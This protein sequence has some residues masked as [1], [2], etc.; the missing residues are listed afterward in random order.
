M[1]RRGWIT[2]AAAGACLLLGAAWWLSFHRS[3]T[4]TAAEAGRTR[5]LAQQRNDVASSVYGT[6]PVKDV[7]SA[8]AAARGGPEVQVLF[9]SLA[10]RKVEALPAVREGLHTG[11]MFEKFMLTKFLQY[12]PWPEVLADLV[13]LAGDRTQYWLPRQGALYALATLGDKAAGPAVAEIL[14]EPDC[15]QGVQLVA[16]AALARMDYR[17][18]ADTIRPF[19][20]REDIHMRLFAAHALAGWG[21][22][23]DPALLSAALRSDDYIARQEA[24]EVLAVTADSPELLQRASRD[25]PHE[26]VRD[27]AKRALLARQLRSETAEAK[28]AILSDALRTAEPRTATWIVRTM[29]EQGGAPGRAAVRE[30]AT[31]DD[32]IGERSRAYLILTASR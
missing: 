2:G 10:M 13:A 8:L 15:P 20:Q 7:V 4:P 18:A 19:A 28:V 12:C 17:E 30:L 23:V 25:D 5:R 16:I 32:R 3:S 11:A 24:C 22:P 14:R 6:T 1:N 29:L 31:R 26:A 27:A 21:E 9:Q